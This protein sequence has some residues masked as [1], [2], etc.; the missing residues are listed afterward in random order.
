MKSFK[1]YISPPK[2]P[3][4]DW[5]SSFAETRHIARKNRQRLKEEITRQ[6]VRAN[7]DNYEFHRDKYHPIHDT[8]AIKGREELA[9]HEIEAVKHYTGTSSSDPKNGESSSRNMNGYLRRRFGNR[10]SGIRRGGSQ[11]K[12]ESAIARLSGC[13]RPSTTNSVPVETFSGVPQTIG[14]QLG[15]MKPGETTHLPGFTSTSTSKSVARQFCTW[16]GGAMDVKSHIMK[17]HVH[18]GAGLSVA[19]H[20]SHVSDEP[21]PF[22]AALGDIG[23]GSKGEDEILLHHGAKI[24]KIGTERDENGDCIHH[25]EVHHEHLPLHQYPNEYDDSD[26]K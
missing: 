24:T 18:P 10:M 17:F 13:F 22:A 19:R 25:F 11:E 1:A 23:S 9:P 12:V 15:E 5:Q 2:N 16:P 21:D 7:Y 14:R 8:L 3:F 4:L 6:P 26:R 20:S